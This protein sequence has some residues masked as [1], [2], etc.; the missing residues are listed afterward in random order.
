MARQACGNTPA[1][2]KKAC[3]AVLFPRWMMDKARVW[4]YGQKNA[5]LMRHA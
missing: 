2:E 4:G 3:A 5:V 1:V